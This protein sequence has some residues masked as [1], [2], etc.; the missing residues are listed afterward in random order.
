MSVLQGRMHYTIFILFSLAV[1]GLFPPPLPFEIEIWMR[2]PDGESY[3]CEAVCFCIPYNWPLSQ[4]ITVSLQPKSQGVVNNVCHHFGLCSSAVPPLCLN[5]QRLLKCRE[6]QISHLRSTAG[7]PL[8][9]AQDL[10]LMSPAAHSHLSSPNSSRASNP[11]E[12]RLN[13]FWK[14]CYWCM[15]GGQA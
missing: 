13:G 5:T 4:C 1:T 14:T 12:P 6:R 11:F 3:S 2:N 7:Q 8:P 15:G 9:Y 10:W